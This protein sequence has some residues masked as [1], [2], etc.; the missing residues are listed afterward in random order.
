MQCIKEGTH[1]IAK[2]VSLASY[3][4]AEVTQ[5]ERTIEHVKRL[6]HPNLFQLREVF[7]EKDTLIQV[8]EYKQGKQ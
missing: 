5:I 6:K 1:Y 3:S 8:F 4:A 2:R 7:R